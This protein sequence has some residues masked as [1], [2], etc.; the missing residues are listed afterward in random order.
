MIFHISSLDH[1][2]LNPA[3]AADGITIVMKVKFLPN[4]DDR[5]SP[6][7]IFDSGGYHGGKGI[8]MYV[9]KEELHCVVAIMD[10][11]WTVRRFFYFFRFIQIL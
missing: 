1:F 6:R 10:A 8:S 5:S 3:L 9:E 11:M 2:L 4:S 7:F